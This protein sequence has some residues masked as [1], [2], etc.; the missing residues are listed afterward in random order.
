M[1]KQ[2]IAVLG[3][4]SW[5]TALAQVLNDNGH[6]VRIWGNITEQIDELNQDHT[7]TRSFKDI[8]LDK[9]IIGYHDLG[10][11]LD[12]ADAVLF[13]VPTKVTRLV[14]KQVA[15][16]LKHKV[17]VMHA[18]KGLEPD[19]HER[20]STILEEEIPADLRSEV[21]V[22]SGPSHAEETIVRDITLITAASKD[23]AT[24]K[25]VQELFSNRYFR[26]YTNT[27]VI[28]VET[29]GALKNII[30]V[31]AGALHGLGY[32]DNAKAAII[33]RGLAEITRLGVAMGASPL[34]YSG[35]SG[36]GDLIVTGTSIHSRN[37]RAGDALG[38]GEKLED[39]ETNMGMVIEGIS[40]TKVAYELAQEL[41]VYMPITSAIYRT[42]Y[43]GADIKE[44]ILDMM[45]NEFRS[46]NEW[47][48]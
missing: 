42:I 3:P 21:V 6:E 35:L 5:G 30:A 14:A 46:E 33:T 28:G 13:V 40:T 27:D 7:N 36:V 1:S 39:I 22:V 8:I 38:R 2:T 23:L 37:W 16:A 15:K 11:A 4:G 29:A 32:G 10:Q 47:T 41:G 24:A 26:L 25:Y 48:E 34:T 18:S 44:S 19:T 9:K 12:G 43:E 31:G 45:S 20:L 17:T